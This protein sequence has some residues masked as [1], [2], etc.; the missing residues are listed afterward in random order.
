[1]RTAQR[2]KNQDAYQAG[3]EGRPSPVR[4]VL[5]SVHIH[6]MRRHWSTPLGGATPKTSPTKS[7]ARVPTPPPPEKKR[8]RKKVNRRD[9]MAE[10]GAK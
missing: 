8:Q 9:A 1:M 6:D 10:D 2:K 3:K 4:F 5:Y 7:A